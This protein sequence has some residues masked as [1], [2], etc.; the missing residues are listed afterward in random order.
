MMR[1]LISSVLLFAGASAAL[2]FPEG[3][4]KG[5]TQ[6]DDSQTATATVV[7]KPAY[8]LDPDAGEPTANLVARY[9]FED[10]GAPFAGPYANASGTSTTLETAFGTT[11]TEA[12]GVSRVMSMNS[13]Y[14][15]GTLASG[16]ADRKFT[17]SMWFKPNTGATSF[18]TLFR[19]DNYFLA[20]G[21]NSPLVIAWHPQISGG[22]ASYITIRSNAINPNGT[23]P[24]GSIFNTSAGIGSAANATSCRINFP[25]GKLDDLKWHHLIVS[26]DGSQTGIANGGPFAVYLDS[27]ARLSTMGSVATYSGSVV[28]P[29]TTAA[30]NGRAIRFGNGSNYAVGVPDC[31]FQGKLDRVRVYSEALGST[32]VATLMGRDTDGDGHT[33]L[34][35]VNTS[36]D[37]P[38]DPS[39]PVPTT[40]I[41]DD[42]NLAAATL[43]KAKLGRWDFETLTSAGTVRN[44]SRVDGNGDLLLGGAI[45]PDTPGMPSRSAGFNGS[46]V[47][48]QTPAQ[49]LAGWDGVNNYSAGMWIKADPGGTLDGTSDRHALWGLNSA[50]GSDSLVFTVRS[51]ADLREQFDLI[52]I[53]G[54]VRGIQWTPSSRLGFTDGG[55]HHVLLTRTS[56]VYKLYVNGQLIPQTSTTGE[57]NWHASAFDSDMRLEVGGTTQYR[58]RYLGWMGKIDRLRFWS[59]ALD[60]AD[61]QNL[62]LQSMDG[63][64]I[65][66]LLE[67]EDGTLNPLVNNGTYNPVDPTWDQSGFPTS[68]SVITGL[69]AHWNFESLR[70]DATGRKFTN[71]LND[72]TYPLRPTGGVGVS[73]ADALASNYATFSETGSAEAAL[74]NG[75]YKAANARFAITGWLKLAKGAIRDVPG[76]VTPL[77]EIRSNGSTTSANYL[78]LYAIQA[79]AYTQI[80]LVNVDPATKTAVTGERWIVPRGG[81]LDNGGWH[82]LV[83]QLEDSGFAFY[84]DNE[85]L[86][87][88]S[89][90]GY[91]PVSNGN[92][93]TSILQIGAI[94]IGAKGFGLR[95]GWDRLRVY[96]QALGLG[97][98]AALWNQDADS[99]GVEDRRETGVPGRDPI[100]NTDGGNPVVQAGA[101]LARIDFDGVSRNLNE[102]P[103]LL[104]LWDFEN[105]ATPGLTF[106]EWF[107]RTPL[108]PIGPASDAGIDLGSGAPSRSAFLKSGGY[109]SGDGSFME[110]KNDFTFSVWVKT[111]A[112]LLD[113]QPKGFSLISLEDLIHATGPNT[114]TLRLI[115]AGASQAL[116]V[117]PFNTR[118]A[119]P[120]VMPGGVAWSLLDK[121][122]D[123]GGWHHVVWSRHARGSTIYLDGAKLGEKVGTPATEFT[124]ILAEAPGGVPAVLV[125]RTSSRAPE[126]S[127]EGNVD[128]LRIY[129]RALTAGEALALYQQDFDSDGYTD[130]YE[131]SSAGFDPYRASALASGAVAGD[132]NTGLNLAGTTVDEGT[133][134]VGGLVGA[135]NFE[136]PVGRQAGDPATALRFA[137]DAADGEASGNP[138]KQVVADGGIQWADG[139]M[140][141]KALSTSRDSYLKLPPAI[142]GESGGA[143]TASFWMRMERGEISGNAL[144]MQVFPQTKIALLT[145][146]ANKTL[147]PKVIVSINHEG[148]IVAE[149]SFTEVSNDP[150]GKGWSETA[151]GKWSSPAK[152]DDGRWHH[153]VIDLRESDTKLWV[154]AIPAVA[155]GV[156]GGFGGYNLASANEPYFWMGFRRNALLDQENVKVSQLPYTGWNGTLDRVRIYTRSLTE[157]ATT[158]E[159]SAL[160]NQDFDGDSVPDVTEVN[161]LIPVF[162]DTPY[163]PSPTTGHQMTRAGVLPGGTYQ[164]SGG[165]G[166]DFSASYNGQDATG[167]RY[168]KLSLNG[169]PLSDQR[170]EQESESDQNPEETYIDAFSLGLR[171]D[172]SLIHT[173]VPASD[174]T[175]QVNLSLEQESW[176]NRSGLKPTEKVTQPFGPC[177]TSNLCAYVEETVEVGSEAE[178]DATPAPSI[179][180][181][182]IDEDGRSLRFGSYDG[183]RIFAYP[184]SV[185]DR[186]SYQHQLSRA[187]VST[188][189]LRKKFGTTLTYKL[190]DLNQKHYTNRAGASSSHLLHRYYRLVTVEDRY[191]NQLRYSYPDHNKT[192]LPLAI[193]VPGRPDL[194]IEMTI[195]PSDPHRIKTVKDPRGYVHTFNYGSTNIPNGALVGTSFLG[196]LSGV[197]DP[198]GKTVSY[199]YVPAFEID[200]VQPSS[201][202]ALNLSSVTDKRGV[203][204]T[205]SYDQDDA[206]YRSTFNSQGRQYFQIYGL[207][208]LV[209]SV[210]RGA[211]YPVG[212]SGTADVEQTA[213]FARK[214]G[215]RWI[216]S[217]NGVTVTSGGSQFVPVNEWTNLITDAVGNTT[218]YTFRDVKAVLSDTSTHGA[219]FSLNWLI[220]YL[221]MQIGH[222]GGL[223]TESY[224]FDLASGLSLSRT[225][226]ICNN[227]TSYRYANDGN[228]WGGGGLVP[229]NLRNLAL[230][231]NWSDPISKTDAL[232]RTESYRYSASYRVMDYQSDI[233]GTVSETGVDS[234]GRRTG[235]TV[236]GKDGNILS[237][238]SYYYENST[239]RAFMTRKVVHAFTNATSSGQAW[240][241]DIVHLY[242]PDANGRVATEAIDMNGNGTIQFGTDVVTSF[243][244]NKNGNKLT[245]TDPRGNQTRFGYDP[246]GRLT[247]VTHPPA[248]GANRDESR[249]KTV[250]YDGNGNKH[251]EIDENGVATIRRFDPLG[252]VSQEIRDLD[253]S[254]APVITAQTNLDGQAWYRLDAEG[255]ATGVANPVDEAGDLVATY[256]Y[257]DVNTVLRSTD[258]RGVT[259]KTDVDALQRPIMVW[260]N[261]TEGDSGSTFD[262]STVKRRTGFLYEKGSNTGG[263]MFSGDGFKPT[264][265]TRYAAVRR[266]DGWADIVSSATFDKVY[267]PRTETTGY[268]S[269]KSVTNETQYNDSAR[270]ITRT[271]AKGEANERTVVSRMD[272]LGREV[273]TTADP[274]GLNAVARVFHSSTGLPWK[275]VDPLLRE[276]R[277][278]YD[279][280]GRA[281]SVISAAGL[282]EASTV[283][284][285]YDP[286]GN[287]I[288]VTDPMNKVTTVVYDARNR[289]ISAL[290]P[291]VDA[292]GNPDTPGMTRPETV[293]HYNG[294]GQVT[295]QRDARGHWTRSFHDRAN[296]LRFTRSNPDPSKTPSASNNPAVNGPFDIVT[297]NTFDAAGNILAVRD[298]NDHY[299]RN[300]WDALGRMSSTATDPVDGDPAPGTTSTGNEI[301]VSNQYDDSGNLILVTD[302]LGR[303][304]AFRFDGLGRKTRTFWDPDLDLQRTEQFHFDGIVQTHRIDPK[305]QRT[306]YVWDKL[307]R[308]TEI[309]Y[310]GLAADKRVNTFDL[311]GNLL[312]VS[313]PNETTARKTTRGVTQTFD[314]LNR[315]LTET[316]N[317]RTHTATFDRSGNRLT[318]A[319]QGGRTITSSY[320][321]LNR[322]ETATEST[323]VTR[324]GYDLAGNV[325]YKKLPNDVITRTSF[326]ALNRRLVVDDKI[327]TTTL[328]KFDYSQSAGPGLFS[329]HDHVGNLLR[330]VETYTR[331]ELKNRIVT[332]SYDAA[333]RLHIETLDESGAGGSVTTTTYENDKGNNRIAKVKVV[334]TS[335]VEDFA[336]TYGNGSNASGANSNQLTGY[337]PNGG[338]QTH[339]FTYDTNGNRRT[340][341]TSG[342]TDTYGYD[343]EN[344]LVSLNYQTPAGSAARGEFRY[345]YDHRTR[346]VAR[347]ESSISGGVTSGISFS[348]GLSVQELSGSTIT[349]HY[350]RGSD[351]GGGIG[352]V[353]YSMDGSL[354]A[355][356]DHYNSRGD[357]IG[358]T[359]ASAAV[360]WQAAYEAYGTKKEGGSTATRQ[361]ANTKDE[362]PHGLLNEGFR[363][364]DLEAGVFITRDPLGFVDG[365]NVYTYVRQNPWSAFDTHGLESRLL[366]DINSMGDDWFGYWGG[367]GEAAGGA[368]SGFATA[369]WNSHPLVNAVQLSSGNK[370]GYQKN[371][372]G[373]QQ[374]YKQFTKSA[375][376]LGATARVQERT[377][378]QSL[379][380]AGANHVDE[381]TK[382][383]KKAGTLAFHGVTFL[384][385]GVDGAM[386]VFSKIGSAAGK[387][388]VPSARGTLAE[389]SEFIGP[390]LPEWKGPVDY[391][392]LPD[393]R[394]VGPGKPFTQTQKER[395]RAFNMEQN[396]GI[397][398]SDLDGRPLSVPEK[399]RSGV[400]ANMNQAEIDHVNARSKGGANSSSNAQLLSKK[401]NL[402]KSDN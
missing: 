312:L 170:P 386:T 169:R 205:F 173:P 357:V 132:G 116:V 392:S 192:L 355:L 250:L 57:A 74:A 79:G 211:S 330:S 33:D 295:A 343:F 241:T 66:D 388:V 29:T 162:V 139:G 171:H 175:L 201:H 350:I 282:P 340:R 48:T 87:R 31:F 120:S 324:Y 395:T 51:L 137:A 95:G 289:K 322:L 71:Q 28:N 4:I 400:P 20:G 240:E 88:I 128:R 381:A 252:R 243:T 229:S 391:S 305:N 134:L 121:R 61:A 272:G 341:T 180:Y 5:K 166:A 136:T 30:L 255:F 283:T 3:T 124:T 22:A 299:T 221:E 161:S 234:L 68:P 328:S 364:R 69:V 146:G 375:E 235:L 114:L 99:D 208:R 263:S 89:V 14:V 362:D 123:D 16:A 144:A 65:P 267:R 41:D 109:L 311:A 292:D 247:L 7:V 196:T 334:G 141:S 276:T 138:A 63:D 329:G 287:V 118:T 184:G 257:N 77:Y 73:I 37:A 379:L 277:S 339:V 225:V 92:L 237:R 218:T 373:Y 110:G 182:A 319:Y 113:R 23:L 226:D 313:Y 352:G 13:S 46:A 360:T 76:V 190:T 296:R 49:N 273:E 176:N 236:T 133:S 104:G 290:G 64:Q 50:H 185:S 209:K 200:P 377:M 183:A 306:D 178:T 93:A 248:D 96:N 125:G 280:A 103:G 338:G 383:P 228:R 179:S 167:P 135:W 186:K 337:G 318:I 115:P 106:K 54:T 265:T 368:I 323:R 194:R 150:L 390:R 308:N 284:N 11:T 266:V 309:S 275:T 269:G 21:T 253:G 6:G 317:G 349:R 279:A 387:L 254:G 153:V 156:I 367:V 119:F 47:M 52:D 239:F 335:T 278:A 398:R 399:S 286:A 210:R 160:Y 216:Y 1:F 102:S 39:L 12:G 259:T 401:Q 127:L 187:D 242:E 26:Y 17:L 316:S 86:S 80:F 297:V 327:G 181:S 58:N 378:A 158:K 285:G 177:W 224:S 157:S 148:K 24:S 129:G 174:L 389:T 249:V 70:Y 320:D 214:P 108:A 331:T 346:R 67:L 82:H 342:R 75:I 147:L 105:L 8:Y 42:A 36:G 223:G 10:T 303:Q 155:N 274:G 233:Y 107:N 374:A 122:L 9:D 56:G 244:Y 202:F 314:A 163:V 258:P 131:M 232:G 291:E 366:N 382:N 35:E 238:E 310:T 188:L 40:V 53:S 195:D 117:Q 397:L 59:A 206:K 307:G 215:L 32:A 246:L 60:Q 85:K 94:Q 220:Y 217:E 348:G 231:S 130:I 142:L 203:S 347:D 140:L 165:S 393:H 101:D 336:Y 326:D 380:D 43:N 227:V 301:I 152:L 356:F 384:A 402:Q 98:I 363:Y 245:A 304:T 81:Q 100:S 159:V 62:Y 396:E 351:W 359:N 78:R 197:T 27:T 302:G 293:I 262:G 264:T 90:P 385:G 191:G 19:M 55:W 189:V 371:F 45:V 164:A 151:L 143:L 298:G 204:T 172:T 354:N 344:R 325:I 353:L 365:P 376:N 193:F 288:S 361:K 315:V 251:A 34:K 91:S 149:K 345:I 2:S 97:P 321:A 394:S 72:T 199:S 213:T 222:P 281:A 126:L 198:M 268:D 372:E 369:T 38:F 112:A 145:L 18:Q 256:L 154:D 230:F 212:M 168:R 332:N 261:F 300:T 83:F 44:L 84:L 207:P 358:Q 271:Q 294:T 15:G 270:T 111:S 370:T 260:E 219:S 333:N 25:V